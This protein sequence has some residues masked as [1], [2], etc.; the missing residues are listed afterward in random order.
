MAVQAP[1]LDILR[2]VFQ[3][4]HFSQVSKMSLL[5]QLD[6]R[7]MVVTVTQCLYSSGLIFVPLMLPKCVVGCVLVGLSGDLKVATSQTSASQLSQAAHLELCTAL[8]RHTVRHTQ[9]AGVT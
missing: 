7:L 6:P 1:F 3:N 9:W 2:W 5:F 4:P 8:V